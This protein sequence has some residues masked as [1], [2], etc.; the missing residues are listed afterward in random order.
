MKNLSSLINIDRE[1]ACF[2][3]CTLQKHKGKCFR[4]LSFLFHE[5]IT[6]KFERK[7]QTNE[8]NNNKIYINK[9]LNLPYSVHLRFLPQL[10]YI[11]L[12]KHDSMIQIIRLLKRNATFSN[13]NATIS[14]V[15]ILLYP[16]LFQKVSDFH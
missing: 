4:S 5:M 15:S 13:W 6:C 9:V 3:Y 11:T 12:I 2:Q 16:L 10:I 14:S 8:Q 7:P 1:T